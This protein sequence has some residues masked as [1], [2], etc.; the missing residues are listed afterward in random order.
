MKKLFKNKSGVS[1]VV[2]AVIM[3]L[4]VMLSMSG[5]F[6]F[7]VNY[8]RDFQTGS[9]GA[10]FESMTVEDLW[11][12]DDR[13]IEIWVYNFGKADLNITNVYVDNNEVGFGPTNNVYI[14]V[15]EHEKITVSTDSSPSISPFIHNKSYQFKIVTARGTTFEGIYKWQ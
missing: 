7:F 3:I 10:V 4:I 14:A 1:P 15:G 2:S 5:L 9:G 13:T 11:F 8:S 12:S 6:G